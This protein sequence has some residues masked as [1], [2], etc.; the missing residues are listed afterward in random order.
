VHELSAHPDDFTVLRYVAGD[1]DEAERVE[2]GKHFEACS[3]CSK[4]LDEIRRVDA[5]LHALAGERNSFEESDEAAFATEDPFRRRP[6][7]RPPVRARGAISDFDIEAACAASEIGMKRQER[8]L[9]ALQDSKHVAEAL[10]A[11]DLSDAADRFAILYAL[12]G[13]GQR[14]AESPAG[15]LGF[16]EKTLA[17][18]RE[19][20]DL[21]QS[22]S[23]DKAEQYVPGLLLT[24]QAHLLA[25]QACIWIGEFERASTHLTLAYRS[26][27]QSGRDETSLATVE[28]IESQRRSFTG[29]G[30]EGL[31][32][33]KRATATFEAMGLE[34]MAARAKVSQ[35]LALFEL[36]EQEE[37]VRTYR[38]TLPVFEKWKLWSNY[39][40][41]LNSIGTS[42]AK[43]GR[44]DEARREYAKALQRF[45]HT[46]HR[47]WLGF[48]RHGLA[49]VL[50]GAEKYR[51]A[52][53]ALAQASRVYAA[54]GAPARS[55]LASLHEIES[56]A[57]SGDLSRARHRLEIFR[58]EVLRQGVLDPFVAQRV[59]AALSGVDPDLHNIAELRRQAEEILSEQ[60]RAM[61]A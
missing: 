23:S 24:A 42:L 21:R 60:L 9:V 19:R 35:G 44:L 27:A 34:E 20:N 1:L 52:A 7:C 43:L 11:L 32:L 54:C 45:S 47:S 57:R 38:Q 41:A 10:D 28:H 58:G 29:R 50:F 8:L 33:A 16:A 39:V 12:Q 61:P 3:S 18:G 5:E 14:I 30:R 49:D 40:G 51:E 48:I 2:T 31:L 46:E 59:E 4:V 13:A 37:A 36:D 53:I 15:A 25:G 55:L 6:D 56:W 26:F 22:V 17:Q